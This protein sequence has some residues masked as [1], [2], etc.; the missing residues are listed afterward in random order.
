MNELPND[1]MRE[2]FDKFPVFELKTFKFVCRYWKIRISQLI[3][4]RKCEA[5]KQHGIISDATCIVVNS[6]Y[7]CIC[8]PVLTFRISLDFPY[9]KTKI[10]DIK[11]ILIRLDHITLKL[12][13]MHTEM[14][15]ISAILTEMNSC[16]DKPDRYIEQKYERI[17]TIGLMFDYHLLQ[18]NVS[19]NETPKVSRAIRKRGNKN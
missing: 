15:N 9:V 3:E 8:E 12:A 14:D 4:I 2:I 6:E 17:Q 13:K 19:W 16:I 5:L 7:L 1:M 18:N 11:R 10:S